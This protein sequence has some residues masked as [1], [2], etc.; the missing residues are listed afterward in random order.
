MAI[1][2]MSTSSKPSCTIGRYVNWY[3][4]Y[5]E[6]YG[7]LYKTKI[8]LLYDPAIQVLGIYLEKT[9]ILRD[10][11]TLV[12]TTALFTIAKKQKQPKCP[13]TEEWIKKLWCIYTVGYCIF[14]HKIMK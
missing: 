3:N 13:S 12:F 6:Q 8:D 10:T 7:A 9:I 4:H 2:K 11:Y 5:G 1:I 14:S